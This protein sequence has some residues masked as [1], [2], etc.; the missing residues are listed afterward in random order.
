MDIFSLGCVLAEIFIGHP[1]FELRIMQAY[2]KGEIDSEDLLK[3][4]E[5]HCIKELIKDMIRLDPLKRKNIKQILV[6]WCDKVFPR[7]YTLFLYQFMGSMLHPSI[8]SPDRRIAYIFKYIDIIWN[9]CFGKQ[10]PPLKRPINSTLFEELRGD[11]LILMGCSQLKP[12]IFLFCVKGNEFDRIIRWDYINEHSSIEDREK[13]RASIMVIIN[14]IGSMLQYCKLPSTKICGLAILR[15]IAFEIK[16]VNLI[17]QI[18]L[19]HHISYIRDPITAVAV[20]AAEGGIELLDLIG[21]KIEITKDLDFK[22]FNMYIFPEYRRLARRKDEFYAV[23]TFAKL[24]GKLA[25]HGKRLVEK[26]MLA[27]IRYLNEKISKSGI[28]NEPQ[29][30]KVS[31]IARYDDYLSD[32]FNYLYSFCKNVIKNYPMY[33]FADIPNHLHEYFSIFSKIIDWQFLADL[34]I[35][36][37]Y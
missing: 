26:G 4:I 2:K 10:E 31:D 5:D 22:I 18:I 21:D 16:D 12:N 13:N 3:G 6:E 25:I 29:E 9:V 36:H 27:H 11:P 7:S 32:I 33:V 24:L 34:I 8:C 28:K 15:Q 14:V 1:I 35:L 37:Q 23:A 30:K 19:P 20:E 17:M